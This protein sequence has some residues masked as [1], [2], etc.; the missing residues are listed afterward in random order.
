MRHP[1]NSWCEYHAGPPLHLSASGCAFARRARLFGTT[2]RVAKTVQ[3]GQG[4]VSRFRVHT[5]ELII[6]QSHEEVLLS[7]KRESMNMILEYLVSEKD[8]TNVIGLPFFATRS[9]AN[10]ALQAVQTGS[11]KRVLLSA[12]EDFFADFDGDAILLRVLPA[13]VSQVLLSRGHSKLDIEELTGPRIH[14]YVASCIRTAIESDAGL[15][16]LLAFW[17]WLPTSEFENEMMSS[18]SFLALRSLP[19]LRGAPYAVREGVFACGDNLDLATALETLSYHVLHLRFSRNTARMLHWHKKLS[20]PDDLRALVR[21]LPSTLPPGWNQSSAT[22]L[23]DHVASVLSRHGTKK[24]LEPELRTGLRSLPI[25]EVCLTDT[26]HPDWTYIAPGNVIANISVE[27]QLVPTIPATTFVRSL[28]SVIAKHLDNLRELGRML[29]YPE[30]TDLAVDHLSEQSKSFRARF[31]RNI[32]TN[33]DSLPPKLLNRLQ[34]TS[35]VETTTNTGLRHP[36]DLLDPECNIAGLYRFDSPRLPSMRDSDSVELV[37]CLSSLHLLR[38]TFTPVII[39]ELILYIADLSN[40]SEHRHTTSCGLLDLI[41][42]HKFQCAGLSPKPSWAAWLPTED[43]GFARAQECFD[44]WLHK[45]ELFDQVMPVLAAEMSTPLRKLLGM[46][47]PVSTQVVVQQLDATLQ[48]TDDSRKYERLLIIYM[49]LGRR[50]ANGQ[51]SEEIFHQLTSLTANRAWIPIEPGI[52]LESKHAA[53]DLPF[54]DTS[55]L[56]FRSVPSDLSASSGVRD[57]FERMGCPPT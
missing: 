15:N 6:P 7:L 19:S 35:F 31:V 27:T 52:T 2:K 1:H 14:R 30:I 41:R 34:R 32:L 51:I 45:R 39:E 28:D 22:A 43:N 53:F 26:R 42:S 8:V 40:P 5:L 54:P 37:T 36:L 44:P 57:L 16:W 50:H 3:R 18:K 20:F 49:E 17:D 4:Q 38:T 25:Y 21:H 11:M 13:A 56:Q 55:G 10:I 24:R 33:K 9:H 12:S 48:T 47:S 23:R 46:G 29:T